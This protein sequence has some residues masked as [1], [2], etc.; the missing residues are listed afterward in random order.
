[1]FGSDDQ[2]AR[3]KAPRPRTWLIVAGVVLV[4]FTVV[5]FFVL[6]PIVKSQAEQRLSKELGRSVTLGKVKINPYALSVTVENFDIREKDGSSSFL[7]WDRLYVN[8]DALSSLTGD[9]VL[10]E[11]DLDGFHT[12]VTVRADGTYNFSDLIAR[13]EA[14]AP[15]KPVT[16]AAPTKPMRPLRVGRLAVSRARV[17]FN[18]H[19]RKHPFTSVIGPATFVLTGFRTAG[20]RGA[21]YH[22]EATSEAGE[23]VGWTGTLSADPL[24]SRGEFSVE[25]LVLKKYTP[26]FEERVRA[27]LADGKLTVRGHYEAAIAAGKQTLRLTGGEVH[28]QKLR[29]LERGSRLPAVELPA[30]DVLGIDAD[31]VAMKGSI[32]SVTA[33]GGHL[34]VR[35]E[36]D[37]T[38]N[39]LAM[40][41]PDTVTS[42]ASSPATPASTAAPTSTAAPIASA[43]PP[44]VRVGQVTLKDMKVDLTDNAAPR[45]AHLAFSNLQLSV[46]NLTLADNAVMPLQL[47]LAWFPQGTVQVDGT[48]TIKPELTADVK[49]EVT[50][51]AILPLSP[52]LEEFVNAR[53]TQGTVTTK[54]A[55]QVTSSGGKPVVTF[56]GDVTVDKFALVDGVHNEELAG[57]A[58][59]SLKGIKASTA[60]QLGVALDE[61][62]IT[63]PYARVVVNK[64]K[65]INLLGVMPETPTAAVPPTAT[66][67]APEPKVTIG[68]VIIS[69]GD[70]S[71][72]DRSL[73]PNVRLGMV[74]FGGTISG[75]SSE[76]L[77]RA[78]VDLK[79]AVD[80]AGPV[81][82]SGKLDP[83]GPNKFID[84]K[85]DFKNVDLLPMSPYSGKFAGYELARGK[86]VVDTKVHVEGRKL[87][88]TNVITLHQF[89]FGAA[90]NSP[91]ATSL[92]VR[93]GVALLKD[94][95][96]KIVVDMPVQG[97]LDDPNFRIGKVVWRVIGNLLTKAATSPFSL[98]GSMFGGGGEE[99]AFQEFAPG[100]SELQPAQQPKLDVLVKALANRP[101]LSLGIEGSYDATADAYALKRQKL[102]DLVRRRIWEAKHAKDPNIAPPEQLVITPEENATM[103]RQLFNAKFPPGTKFG[104]P[105][106]PEPAVAAPPPPPPPGMVRKV[107]NVITFEEMRAKRAAKKEEAR[108]A[109]EHEKAVAIAAATGL[110]LDEMT[111]RLAETMV[112]TDNDL[113][114][115]A[116]TRAEHVRDQLVNNGHIAAER[117]FLAQASAAVKQNKGPRVFLSLQ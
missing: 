98:I 60:P 2:F 87:D 38:I 110:P 42:A 32:Q 85:V 82:I 66:P 115:L 106:P 37:G 68:R 58:E 116:T 11:V 47:S 24:E 99:L 55:V 83:L 9:W 104:T 97:S 40:V 44:D 73:E 18:D 103:V 111:G 26:Y 12:A 8:F 117:L 25:N 81:A 14:M 100:S 50:A 75:L 64:D 33:T 16:A 93:L 15:A 4:V 48:F 59:L 79:G 41:N 5:G 113:R 20:A 95:D 74:Q 65:S 56:T 46:K 94:A 96:G 102:A 3:M 17:D 114:A 57:F 30:L 109:A 53:I 69:N 62:A 23:S 35:R 7:G 107:I 28:L 22:F 71:F 54:H 29:M 101:A 90:T 78:D 84:L 70:F 31:A 63:A 88:S 36:K 39:L 10:S 92:P 1:M 76:N 89:T 52:Y 34:G 105:L 61:V 27:D 67:A 6:P 13:L 108:R 80:G 86:L 91:D 112:V 77:A 72:T 45:P 19:S 51:I 49:T 43:A 21:P